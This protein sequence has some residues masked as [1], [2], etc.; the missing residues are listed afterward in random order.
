MQLDAPLHLFASM[1]WT[2]NID[3]WSEC[4]TRCIPDTGLIGQ[5]HGCC[6]LTFGW[7]AENWKWITARIGAYRST[8]RKT[9]SSSSSSVFFPEWSLFPPSLQFSQG[10]ITGN[11]LLAEAWVN[12]GFW[13]GWK[14]SRWASQTGWQQLIKAEPLPSSHTVL[15]CTK[16]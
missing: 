4:C 2:W 5:D 3:H 8:E 10:L 13:A 15:L 16:V 1:Q 14:V 6:S 7:T 12:P 11:H 9:C